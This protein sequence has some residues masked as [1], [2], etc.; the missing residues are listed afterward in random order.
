MPIICIL[1]LAA[2]ELKGQSTS[3]RDQMAHK[4]YNTDYLALYRKSLLAFIPLYP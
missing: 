2:F 1:P 4:A 3:N